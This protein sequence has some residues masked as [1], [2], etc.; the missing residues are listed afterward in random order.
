MCQAER[1]GKG[2][3]V[4]ERWK[5]QELRSQSGQSS[6]ISQ[7]RNPVPRGALQAKNQNSA[8]QTAVLPLSEE[9]HS[10]VCHIRRSASASLS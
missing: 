8:Q 7:N 10:L 1:T 9:G 4:E 5:I 6:L 3:R 2:P